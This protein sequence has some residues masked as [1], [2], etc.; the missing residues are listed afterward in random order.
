MGFPQAIAAGF[1]N[2]VNFSGRAAR[3]EYWYFVLFLVI[4]GII[5]AII[6]LTVFGAEQIGPTNAIF[7]LATILPSLAVTIRRLHDIG[8]TGWWVLLSFVPLVGI[9]ILII[10]WCRQGE[11]GPNAYGPP[12]AV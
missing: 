9:I 12:P 5:T 2:Y 4:V 10:W 8:R 3:P 6:D 11:A 1:G 7:S